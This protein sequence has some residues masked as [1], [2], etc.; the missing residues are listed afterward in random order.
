MFSEQA[1]RRGCLTLLA[2]GPLLLWTSSPQP[3]LRAASP[4]EPSGIEFNRDIRPILSERCFACHGP[5]KS[6]RK[7]AFRLD[8]Q[9]GI[10]TPLSSGTLA[11]VPGD[12]AASPLW[13]R[14]ASEDKAVRM[15]PAYLGHDR[16]TKKQVDRISNWIEQGA[17]WQAHWSFIAPRRVAEPAVEAHNWPRNPIDYLI[18]S[19]L[20]RAGLK[21]SAEADA[22]RLIRR[23]SLD[24]TGLPPSPLE[25]DAFLND[26]SPQ[27]YEKVVDRLLHS[28]R[29]G[30]RMAASWLDVARYADT[31]GY[32]SDG[33][34]SMWRWRDWVIDA[35]NRNLPFD[36]FTVEQIAGDMLPDATRDQIIATG[37]NRNHRTSAEGGIIDEEFRVDYV[38]DRLETTSTVWLGLTIGCARCHDHKFDPISQ[39]EYYQLFAYF[40]NVPENGFVYN[41]GNEEPLIKA[42]TPEQEARLHELDRELAASQQTYAALQN[43]VRQKQSVWEDWV[44]GSEMSDWSI[45]EGLLLHFPLDGNLEERAGIYGV[46][47]AEPYDEESDSEEVAGLEAKRPMLVDMTGDGLSFVPGSIG[48][49]GRFDGR[50]FVTAGKVVPFDYLDSF[51]LAAWIYPTSGDGAIISS[52]QDQVQGSGHGLY[53][54]S[55]RLRVHF[56]KR[57]SDLGL[58][59]E[60]EEPLELNRWQHV[61]MTYDGKRKADGLKLYVNGESQR[62]RVLFDKML[63]PMAGPEPF[64]IGAGEGS[65]D[66]FQ[67][68]IDEVRVYRRMLS[69]EEAAVLAL[70][71]TVSEIATSSP[72]ARSPAEANKLRFC[73]LDQYAPAEVEEARHSLAKRQRDRREFLESIPSV[74]VM[75]E[76]ETP[77]ETFFLKRG[78]YDA[79]GARVFPAVPKV[80]PPMARDL[81]NNRLGFARWLVDPSNPLTARVTVNRLWQMLFGVG[82]VKTGEDFGTQGERPLHLELLDWLALE[83]VESGWDTKAILKTIVMSATY[84]QSSRVTPELLSQDPEN[85]LLARGPRFRLPATVIRDQA[86]A[87]SGLLVEEIGGPPVKP[88]QPP[89]LWVELAFSGAAYQPDQGENLHRRSLYTY[90][91][92]TIPPPAMTTFDAANRETCAVRSPRTNTPLQALNLMNDKTYVESANRLAQRMLKAGGSTTEARIAYGFRLAT[93]RL[94]QPQEARV[95]SDVFDR[96]KSSHQQDPEATQQFLAHAGSF[97]D[98]ALDPVELAAYT[99]LASLILNLDETI[100]KE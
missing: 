74:M 76:R 43:K 78:A 100:T 39:K 33:K 61:L 46:A 20:E 41:F 18:L 23:L 57:W 90:W 9:E 34:R 6:A 51:S 54:R 56:T 86:L 44:A 52:V 62:K 25:V 24:L 32:Q 60:T 79:P 42:P 3:K 22:T 38:A 77:R 7:T 53:L 91:K 75:K 98:E 81:R 88:Y 82:L 45:Q 11:I 1:S 15:P 31:N 12:P 48:L 50:G 10:L 96:F 29:F 65:T 26:A 5:D 49:A 14:I 21:P 40:N 89:G 58:R 4:P 83:F 47:P 70:R 73:F 85:R 36:R 95:L 72:E 13:Q 92:R 67:G 55:G 69:P 68:Y 2:L 97:G 93:A 71:R 84:R 27:A 59:L 87:V 37:F 99:G 64:R 94:P 16:L 30:E 80:L 8:T 35:F 19:R 66:R 17:K 63:W 28:P